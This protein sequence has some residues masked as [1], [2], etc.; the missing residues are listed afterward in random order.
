ML[1]VCMD[2]MWWKSVCAKCLFADFCSTSHSLCTHSD[3]TPTP[4]ALDLCLQHEC[5]AFLPCTHHA[6]KVPRT[7]AAFHKDF[8][9]LAYHVEGALVFRLGTEEYSR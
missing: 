2:S 3:C 6:V 9:V 1:A 5:H 8:V 4:E 7:N